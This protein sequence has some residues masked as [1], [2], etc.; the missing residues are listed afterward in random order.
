MKGINEEKNYCYK[1]ETDYEFGE[2]VE[3]VKEKLV[4]NNFKIMAEINAKEIFKQ[5]L[6]K[7]FVDYVII[8]V[9]NAKYS[10]R[11]LGE[12][13]DL[14]VFLPCSFI[15]YREDNKTVVAVGEPKKLMEIA[16]NENALET[17]GEVEK[18]FR[19]IIN[20]L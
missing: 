12:D 2:A 10:Y 11:I 7:D 3:K 13:K 19:E 15:I 18:I 9:C 8:S 6:G 1:K 5:K 17:A 14:G 4:E 20:S 16:K